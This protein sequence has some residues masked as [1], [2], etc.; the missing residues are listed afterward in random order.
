MGRSVNYLNNATVIIYFPFESE[1]DENGNFDEDLT[2]LNWDDLKCNLISEIKNKLPSF[3]EVDKWDNRETHIILENN[4]CYIGLSEYCGLVSLSVAP[5]NSDN[6]D[7][8][9]TYR[10]NFAE[11]HSKQIE[12]TLQKI[13]DNI[14]GKRLIKIGSFSN[15][16]GVYKLANKG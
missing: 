8:F 3:Y 2:S 6:I 15:G 11:Y 7:Y 5:R 14:S 4:L 12:K 1:Y 10:D 13:V 16:E 9:L